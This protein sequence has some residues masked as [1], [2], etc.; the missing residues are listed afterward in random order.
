MPF[1][2]NL[3]EKT[4]NIYDFLNDSQFAEADIYTVFDKLMKLDQKAMFVY[5]PPPTGVSIS[6]LSSFQFN[7]KS[8]KNKTILYSFNLHNSNEY[9]E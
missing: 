1:P 8:R 3:I 2:S 9:R 4:R 6:S 7:R 5:T